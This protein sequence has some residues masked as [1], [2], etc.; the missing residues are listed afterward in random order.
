MAAP[1]Q[2]VSLNGSAVAITAGNLHHHGIPRFDR[3][4]GV[5]RGGKHSGFIEDFLRISAVRWGQ[6]SGNCEMP[7]TQHPFEMATGLEF[8]FQYSGLEAFSL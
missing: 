1:P 8:L 2:Y 7:L 6:L 5:N 4:K 3:V